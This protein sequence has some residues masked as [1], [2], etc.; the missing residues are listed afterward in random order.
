MLAE[1]VAEVTQEAARCATIIQLFNTKVIQRHLAKIYEQV[2]KLFTEAIQWYSSSSAF[3]FRASFSDA[4]PKRLEE[5]VT[6]IRREIDS[7]ERAQNLSGHAE[8]RDTHTSVEQIADAMAQVQHDS[9]TQSERLENIEANV[10][11][12][13]QACERETVFGEILSFAGLRYLEFMAKPKDRNLISDLTS[14]PESQLF[15][16]SSISTVST[17]SANDVNSRHT[18]QLALTYAQRLKGCVTG[19]RGLELLVDGER[20]FAEAEV[21]LRLKEWISSTK[22]SSILWI[23]GLVE[24]HSLSSPPR[25]AAF[26]AL[27]AACGAKAPFLAHFCELPEPHEIQDDQ[28]AEE[29]GLLGLVYSLILQLLEFS[30]GDETFELSANRFE[31]LDGNFLSWKPAIALLA[32]LLANTKYVPYCIV[33]NVAVLDYGKGSLVLGELIDVLL[34]R[35]RDVSSIFNVLL[36]SNGRSSI[37]F[38]KIPTESILYLKYNSRRVKHAGRML[39]LHLP[40]NVERSSNS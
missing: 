24:L 38:D 10:S 6:H 1:T 5:T 27:A 36:S 13:R 40:Q 12:C 3:R 26:A 31:Q 15:S 14:I 32:D 35:Q 17:S 8:L 16:N 22:Y 18:R 20:K 9:A 2:F 39:E 23:T 11:R 28:S 7:I 19:S 29:V 34:A 25:T 21:L 33:D 37:L 4:L 30:D